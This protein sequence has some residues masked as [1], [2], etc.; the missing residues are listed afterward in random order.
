M[1]V[2]ERLVAKLEVESLRK[3]FPKEASNFTTWLEENI[4]AL[5]ERLGM[6]LTV[7]QREAVVG[8]FNVDLLCVDREKRR[9][10][11]ENQLEK[12]DHDHLGKVL[13]YLVNL[14]ASTAIWVTAE[15]RAEHLRV[16]EWLNDNSEQG[17]SFYLVKVEAVR[18]ANS[19][20]A[21]LFTIAAGPDVKAKERAEGKKE[22][23]ERH[24]KRL[25]FWK[26]L[27]ARS[28]DRTRLF[29]NITPGYSHWISTGAGKGGVT[30]NY[31]IFSESAA[32]ELYVDNDHE[33]GKGNKL[34]FDALHNQKAEIESEL[35]ASLSWQRLD[36]K[37][38]C[39][40]QWAFSECGLDSPK[41]WPDL[42]DKLIDAMI[43]FEVGIRP[44]LAKIEV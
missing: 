4:E 11:V 24:Y 6:E 7:V 10:I 21:P 36:E 20:F 43:Q 31:V 18:V 38:A 5:S 13:T 39:R 22:L 17:I 23:V 8:D 30:F 15:P 35:G 16:V 3:V 14:E 34:I 37:R 19:P 33:D 25:E 9:V 2:P 32:V 42:Q 27:I 44:R 12:T 40:I 28:K 1:S 26:S 41:G 29:S